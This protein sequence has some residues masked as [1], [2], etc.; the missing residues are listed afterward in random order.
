MEEFNDFTPM[1]AIKEIK[2]FIIYV[3]ENDKEIEADERIS[4]SIKRLET[5]IEELTPSPKMTLKEFWE[6]S[7]MLAI[8]CETEEQDKIFCEES[9]KLGKKWINGE[10]YLE[11][12]QWKNYRENTCYDNKNQYTE[13]SWYLEENYKVLSFEDIEWD[14]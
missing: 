10:S 11:V 8:H 9:D 6:S 3:N 14:C 4:D 13:K 2:D 1:D 12:N 5:L 7:K